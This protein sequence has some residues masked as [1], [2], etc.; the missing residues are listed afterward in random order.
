MLP[1]RMNEHAGDG[2]FAFGIKHGWARPGRA[3]AV[4]MPGDAPAHAADR[5]VADKRARA[6]LPWHQTIVNQSARLA[7]RQATRPSLYL[8]R[9]FRR[10]PPAFPSVARLQRPRSH[11][12]FDNRRS[13]RTAHRMPIA[14]P[15]APDFR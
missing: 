12:T 6:G 14:A 2:A 4:R 15:G 9:S 10:P 13:A 3:T 11:G 8:F 1:Q 7:G 5:R